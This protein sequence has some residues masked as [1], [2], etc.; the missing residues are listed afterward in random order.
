[1]P[2]METPKY[3]TSQ[4][5]LYEI[6]RIGWSNFNNNLPEFAEFTPRYNAKYGADSLAE[7]DAAE[8]MA[9]ENVRSSLS[10]DNRI[11]L[12]RAT[13]SCLIKWQ[14]LKR[15]ILEAY[16][17]E[18]SVV[19]LKA[20]G[21]PL[22]TDASNYKWQSV[23]TLVNGASTF[24]KDHQADLVA[25]DNMPPNFGESF[26]T[27]KD[28]FIDLQTKF[29]GSITDATANTQNKIKA[30]NAVFAKLIKMLQ[31]GQQIF[32]DDEITKQQFVFGNLKAIV[33]G[34]NQA[35]LRGFVT[36][37][38]TGLPV[39]TATVAPATSAYVTI[40]DA[41]G[42]YDLKLAADDYMVTVSAAG[43]TNQTIAVTVK[44]GTVS[45]LNVA[46]VAVH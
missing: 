2:N 8:A 45:S 34:I 9:S 43:Y 29:F 40:T 39:V 11:L 41:D 6:G 33:S 46:L 5:E 16:D 24:I 22:Y 7:I 32:V 21:Q 35:G 19:M 25:N 12:T 18:R 36:D 44:T 37:A 10:E 20:A 17:D 38:V 15:Y 23:K 42:H 26:D 3:N 13:D 14:N 31:D 30:N 1:M 28:I 27:T 4:Q